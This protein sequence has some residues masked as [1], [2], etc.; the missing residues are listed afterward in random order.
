[1]TDVINLCETLAS[2]LGRKP[3]DDILFYGNIDPSRDW[4]G[5]PTVEFALGEQ[6]TTFQFLS[7][8]TLY[9][10]PLTVA[11]RTESKENS[12]QIAKFLY[13]RIAEAL[14]QIDDR[15]NLKFWFVYEIRGTIPDSRGIT[16]GE[17]F[18]SYIEFK[19][20]KRDTKWL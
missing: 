5:K 9:C 4:T 3:Y 2:M 15:L 7:G 18:Y 12:E 8:E 11:I 10:Y 16:L 19:I 6:E 13:P 14:K 20:Y 17:S 1:M